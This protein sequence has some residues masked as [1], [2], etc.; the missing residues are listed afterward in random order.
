VAAPITIGIPTYN[1]ASGLRRALGS[2][3][4]QA[5]LPAE[6]IVS[7]NASQTTEAEQVVKEFVGRFPE[8]RYIR[9]P[10]N[11]GATKNFQWLLDSSSQ[12]YFMWLA[13]DDEFGNATLLESLMQAFLDEPDLVLAFPE[14]R[15]FGDDDRTKWSTGSH[16]K[17]FKDCRTDKEYL[18]AFAGYG[19]G[20]CFY[21]LYSR[22]KLISVNPQNWFDD[23]LK[24]YS[25]GRFL[26]MLFC[27]GGVRF[28]PD[29]LLQYDGRSPARI[30][31]KDLLSAF[32][33]YSK[34]VH[35]FYA[36]SALSI[37]DKALIMAILARSHYPYLVKLWMRSRR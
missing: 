8:L 22:E 33:I 29:A 21:G 11:I 17:V 18:K 5:T 10:T 27:Q 31:E 12:K 37:S 25:E 35:K 15:V 7:D 13:D 1:R 26:H 16:T 14:V 30:S 19:G 28:V 36:S 34:R 24:Y 2:I 3:A 20:H 9:Q 6:I 4:S 23:D 32:A